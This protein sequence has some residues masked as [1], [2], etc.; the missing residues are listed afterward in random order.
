MQ[1][2]S[3]SHDEAIQVL[4]V[5]AYKEGES[6]EE[7]ENGREMFRLALSRDAYQPKQGKRGISAGQ[8]S[9]RARTGLMS[10]HNVI[11]YATRFF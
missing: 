2:T 5:N 8:Q 1:G 10:W 6:G 9:S 4:A 3:P 11:Q 7:M